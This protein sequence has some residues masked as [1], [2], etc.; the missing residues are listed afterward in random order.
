V[1]GNPELVVD[2]VTG[3][4]SEQDR[5]GAAIQRYLTSPGL[6]ARHGAAGRVRAVERFSLDAMVQGYVELYDE[7][8]YGRPNG[9]AA[10]N[11]IA[12]Q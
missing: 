1:G 4:L 5:F 9:L 11:P 12:D 6:R 10:R 3:T 7:V 8:L 2:G